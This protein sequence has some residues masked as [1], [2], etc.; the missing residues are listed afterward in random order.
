MYSLSL[1]LSL[2]LS[3]DTV[4]L[5]KEGAYIPQF[6]CFTKLYVMHMTMTNSGF[7]RGK[8]AGPELDPAGLGY[9]INLSLSAR[10]QCEVEVD[11][12]H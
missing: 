8:R 10:Q 2:S 9:L 12:S 11:Q 3:H 1:S 5:Y 4:L 6:Y 7:W